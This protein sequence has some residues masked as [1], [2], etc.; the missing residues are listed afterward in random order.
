[1]TWTNKGAVGMHA[2]PCGLRPSVLHLWMWV[3]DG[4]TARRS[5]CMLARTIV[6]AAQ[7]GQR[8]IASAE[9]TARSRSFSCA[10]R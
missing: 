3:T 4:R 2:D 10:I 1:M 6:L 8:W 5:K 9:R 7:L